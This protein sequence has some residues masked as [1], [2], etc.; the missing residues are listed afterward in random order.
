MSTKT[1]VEAIAI[2]ARVG[3][4]QL[5][6]EVLPSMEQLGWVDCR[7]DEN[8]QL[9]TVEALDSAER[10]PAR[11][12]P[13]LLDILLVNGLQRAALELI[14]ATSR[15]P[16][17]WTL[18]SS[19]R[20]PWGEEAATNALGHLEAVNLVRRIEREVDR[21]VVFNP[22]IRTNDQQAAAAALR[23]QDARASTEVRAS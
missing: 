13:R 4:R 15:Q 23:A 17:P 22:N 9:V 5:H 6:R 20:A 3:G 18:R 1:R 2:E 14:R 16:L 10:G 7:R 19:V 8:G 21:P 12:A 11:D